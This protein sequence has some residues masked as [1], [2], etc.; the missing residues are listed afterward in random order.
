MREEVKHQKHE[1]DLAAQAVDTSKKELLKLQADIQ[2]ENEEQETRRKDIEKDIKSITLQLTDMKAILESSSA[3]LVQAHRKMALEL[4]IKQIEG[5]LDQR[6]REL[7]QKDEQ[8]KFG[9]EAIQ[10]SKAALEQQKAALADKRD[11]VDTAT[12]ELHAL[13]KKQSSA[14]KI[15]NK[16]TADESARQAKIILSLRGKVVQREKQ[17]K[18]LREDIRKMHDVNAQQAKRIAELEGAE[19]AHKA[20]KEL[21]RSKEASLES[22]QASLELERIRADQATREAEEHAQKIRDLEAQTRQLQQRN[23]D[24]E[25]EQARLAP[26]E[27]L[28]CV[29]TEEFD[30]FQ[31]RY[32]SL[33]RT[34]AGLH[35]DIGTLKCDLT[36]CQHQQGV[37]EEELQILKSEINTLKPIKAEHGSCAGRQKVFERQFNAKVPSIDSLTKELDELR[38]QLEDTSS[39]L[40]S[41]QG[42][43][44]TLTATNERQ[45][46]ENSELLSR[47]TTKCSTADEEIKLL[48]QGKKDL[49]HAKDLIETRCHVLSEQSTSLRENR[50]DAR[51]RSTQDSQKLLGLQSQ[52][53]RWQ[54]E[55]IQA[56]SDLITAREEVTKLTAGKR[57]KDEECSRTVRSHAN[58]ATTLA[59]AIAGK[60]ELG[61]AL[62]DMADKK[63]TSVKEAST[64]GTQLRSVRADLQ[65]LTIEHQYIKIE[66]DQT[67]QQLADTKRQLATQERTGQQQISAAETIAQDA[68]AQADVCEGN[69]KKVRKQLREQRSE[70]CSKHDADMEQADE[71]HHAAMDKVR[72]SAQETLKLTRERLVQEQDMVSDITR[73]WDA[74]KANAMRMA[75]QIKTE[76]ENLGNANK[77]CEQAQGNV[78]RLNVQVQQLT[79]SLDT[80]AT[81]HASV[82]RC[83]NSSESGERKDDE[84]L[85]LIDHY[86]QTA[87]LVLRLLRFDIRPMTKVTRRC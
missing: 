42:S 47:L 18:E 75:A 17:A 65:S 66:L 39:E 36:T 14:K 69:Y 81:F 11:E 87:R 13:E 74:D 40:Q 19:S 32:D 15:V 16:Q 1:A 34:E 43:V 77:T 53:D 78:A 64:L 79:T 82:V 59:D 35:E 57:S 31:M 45:A 37:L 3:N 10:A 5:R 44:D 48:I 24:I 71:A 63:L 41:A 61:A 2:H 7:E 38:I 20:T 6:K 56:S 58:C 4:D 30:S 80:T 9:D 72:A 60:E 50:D 26:F 29:R 86:I 22:A 33:Q 76:Q 55:L 49:E 52:L 28:A 84:L 67:R 83:V 70:L 73:A 46:E 54:Q 23:A 85:K 21:Y 8:L 25:K 12:I 68:K 27:E 62:T 51:Q